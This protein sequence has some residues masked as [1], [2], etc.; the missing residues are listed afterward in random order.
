M[1]DIL[2]G[3]GVV[4]P[5]QLIPLPMVGTLL[6]IVMEY[7]LKS[8][9]IKILPSSFYDDDKKKLNESSEESFE[10]GDRIVMINHDGPARMGMKGTIVDIKKDECC[11]E[12]DNLNIGHSGIFEDS[13][14]NY[15]FVN[16]GDMKSC[17]DKGIIVW[18][19]N[20]KLDGKL[21]KKF[22]SFNELDHYGYFTHDEVVEKLRRKLLKIG[23]GIL[24]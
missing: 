1:L 21:I 8:M 3:I 4:L 16:M 9:G 17:E 7:T 24:V 19:K 12:F 23:G 5:T 18:Y 6:L 15:W 20:G 14:R 11:V 2:K 22:E 10:V 13:R